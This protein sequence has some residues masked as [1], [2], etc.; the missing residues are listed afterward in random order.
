M[1]YAQELDVYLDCPQCGLLTAKNDFTEGYCSDCAAENQRA[2]DE[3]NAS[4][5]RWE[6][7]TDEQRAAEIRRAL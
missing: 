6:R 7:L 1:T 2:L 3:H 4:F 5:D